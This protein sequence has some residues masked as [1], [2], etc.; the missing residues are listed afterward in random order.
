MGSVTMTNDIY[1]MIMDLLMES[2]VKFA[3]DNAKIQ[4]SMMYDKFFKDFNGKIFSVGDP[5]NHRVK[6]ILSDVHELV[7]LNNL[8]RTSINVSVSSKCYLFKGDNVIFNAIGTNHIFPSNDVESELFNKY[9]R[10]PVRQIHAELSAVAKCIKTDFISFA[11]S[12]ILLV[13][14]NGGNVPSRPCIFCRKMIFREFVEK[15]NLDVS[16]VF[17]VSKD[18]YGMENLKSDFQVSI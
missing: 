4:V 9:Y 8:K 17:P 15:R 12:V 13:V 18:I 2:Y 7:S 5:P 10:E 1:D 16:I 14:R 3:G 6:M 11:D